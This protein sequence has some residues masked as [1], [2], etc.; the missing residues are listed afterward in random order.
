MTDSSSIIGRTISHYRVLSKLGGGGMGVVY[1]AEDTKLHR[2]VAL[3]FLPEGLARDQQT[4]QRFQREAQA[5]SALNHPNICTIH[6]VDEYEGQP[7]IAM[8]L[9]EGETLSRR[10]EGK[11]LKTDTLLD[12]AIQIT[13]GLDAAHSE[14]IIHRDIKP[15]NIFVTQRGQAK[16]LDFGLAKI[17]STHKVAEG[18]GIS[19][20]PTASFEELLTTPGVAMGTAPYMSPEQALGEE[21]DARTDLFSLGAVLYEMATGQRPFRETIPSRLTDAILHQPPVTPRTLNAHTS[22]E[23]ERI[24]LKCLEKQPDLRYQSAKEVG[25]DLQRLR[26]GTESGQAFV[27]KQAD[28]T[29]GIERNQQFTPFAVAAICG[30]ALLLAAAAWLVTRSRFGSQPTSRLTTVAILPFQN[31]GSDKDYDFLRFAMPDEVINAL[32]HIPALVIRPF[33]MTRKYANQ[34]INPQCSPSHKL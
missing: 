28:A 22:P 25:V 14:G 3:K 33:S 20:L 27:L 5:A 23:L 15:A 7:F 16:I 12:L 32:S 21:L 11:P 1:K 6:D 34:E 2:S 13:D 30:L 31:M 26:R 4:L 17:G 9:L 29:S 18:T 24:I 8:E 10:V 19:A